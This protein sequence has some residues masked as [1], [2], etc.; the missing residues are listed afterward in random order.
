MFKNWENGHYIKQK[1]V[2]ETWNCGFIEFTIFHMD[3]E[4]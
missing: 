2:L 1:Y 3:I 4:N